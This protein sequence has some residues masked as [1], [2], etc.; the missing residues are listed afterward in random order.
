M[1]TEIKGKIELNKMTDKELI[2]FA[3]FVTE[4]AKC[5]LGTAEHLREFE[6]WQQSRKA[7]VHNVF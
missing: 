1:K 4:T 6:Q 5:Y 2:S 3:L 7:A